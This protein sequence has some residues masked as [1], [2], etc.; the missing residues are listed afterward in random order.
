MASQCNFWKLLLVTFMS[1]QNPRNCKVTEHKFERYIRI[2]DSIQM[3]MK[4][5][6]KKASQS[7][8]MIF[9]LLLVELC[10]STFCVFNHTKLP[11]IFKDAFHQNTKSDCIQGSV[12]SHKASTSGLATRQLAWIRFRYAFFTQCRVLGIR[13]LGNTSNSSLQY[14]IP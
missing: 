12:P 8:N 3:P 2:F 14:T 10:Y 11:R 9:M 5:T 4:V 1:R 7:T 13:V 6:M